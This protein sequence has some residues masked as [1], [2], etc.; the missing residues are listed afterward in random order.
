MAC[1]PFRLTVRENGKQ[2]VCIAG[3]METEVKNLNNL[4]HVS[5]T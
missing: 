3:L 2:K 5:A 4:V 1:R